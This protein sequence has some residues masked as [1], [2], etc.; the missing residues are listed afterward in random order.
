M[1]EIDGGEGRSYPKWN[2]K[3][4]LDLP[5]HAEVVTVEV[6]CKT[7]F[8]DKIVGTA[9]MLASNFAGGYM[10]ESYLHFLSYRLK[11]SR[12]Q[13]NGIINIS[14]RTKVPAPEYS[15]AVSVPKK[16]TVGVPVG[17]SNIGSVVTGVPVLYAYNFNRNL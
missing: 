3:L 4:V 11:D 7:V 6:H 5:P 1:I 16:M 8:G 10:P 14:M 15:F 17:K 12:G 9:S 2:E 13:R